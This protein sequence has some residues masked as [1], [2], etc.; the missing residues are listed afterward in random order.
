MNDPGPS[1]PWNF[2]ID[3]V[4]A[5][6]D[7]GDGSDVVSNLPF[8]MSDID[9]FNQALSSFDLRISS[10]EERISNVIDQLNSIH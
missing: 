3:G 6:L 10:Q 7:R 9:Q 2:V 8:G 4:V 5:K 1:W